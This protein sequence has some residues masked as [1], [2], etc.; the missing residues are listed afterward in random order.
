V[1]VKST[2]FF[3]SIGR[4]IFKSL[5]NLSTPSFLSV[6]LIFNIVCVF[7]FCVSKLDFEFV[8]II[9]YKHTKKAKITV[10]ICKYTNY[11]ST[12]K[13]NTNVAEKFWVFIY[14]KIGTV[15]CT[16]IIWEL[17]V[18]P[19]VDNNCKS[20]KISWFLLLNRTTGFK[21]QY[22][23]TFFWLLIKLQS[24]KHETH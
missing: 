19:G 16:W 2:C 22:A 23:N 18:S 4:A 13:T 21:F 12:H 11:A 1:F 3:I 8:L 7:I 24:V 6:A 20:T 10:Y 17:S 15:Q 14:I 9:F 5:W